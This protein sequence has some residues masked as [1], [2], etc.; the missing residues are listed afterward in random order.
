MSE[1]IVYERKFASANAIKK[2]HEFL[3]QVWDQLP[4]AYFSKYQ[5]KQLSNQARAVAASN[6]ETSVFVQ[7]R[8]NLIEI[9]IFTPNQA[10]LFCF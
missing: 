3:N 7:S 8:K 6:G 2:G 1:S 9:F 10:G 5:L 4:D